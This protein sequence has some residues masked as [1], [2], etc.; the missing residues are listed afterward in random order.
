MQATWFTK[1][2]QA[3]STPL[4]RRISNRTTASISPENSAKPTGPVASGTVATRDSITTMNEIPVSE[5][6]TITQ[7]LRRGRS[8]RP[9][10]PAIATQAG[11][12]Y[13][14]Q[15]VVVSDPCTIATKNE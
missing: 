5:S 10:I 7:S 12:T 11:P 9:K 3:T 8:P 4:S 14:S 2:S 13:W 15:I 6:Q 1:P